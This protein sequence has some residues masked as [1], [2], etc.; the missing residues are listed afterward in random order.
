M[1]DSLGRTVDLPKITV[2]NTHHKNLRSS[3]VSGRC[4]ICGP[5]ILQ[6]STQTRTGFFFTVIR[7]LTTTCTTPILIMRLPLLLCYW[8]CSNQLRP[9]VQLRPAPLCCGRLLHL[10]NKTLSLHAEANGLGNRSP[11]LC[12]LLP[13]SKDA[14]WSLQCTSKVVATHYKNALLWILPLLERSLTWPAPPTNRTTFIW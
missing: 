7:S 9:L 5:P 6:T 12:L 1:Q 8:L 13:C 14:Q 3:I 11:W 2:S 10:H 4:K